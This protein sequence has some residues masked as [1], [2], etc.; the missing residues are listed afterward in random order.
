MAL[1]VDCHDFLTRKMVAAARKAQ[2]TKIEESLPS[3]LQSVHCTVSSSPASGPKVNYWRVTYKCPGCN[4]KHQPKGYW[5]KTSTQ[6][7][8]AFDIAEKIHAV[9]GSCNTAPPTKLSAK[10]GLVDEVTVIALA[11]EKRNRDLTAQA[12]VVTGSSG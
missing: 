2:V 8:V 1:I 4:V 7:S 10:L 6:E 9:H 11:L 3:W 12:R 5:T